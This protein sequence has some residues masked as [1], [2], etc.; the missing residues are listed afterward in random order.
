MLSCSALGNLRSS[1][2]FDSRAFD[3]NYLGAFITCLWTYELESTDGPVLWLDIGNAQLRC[4]QRYTEAAAYH[5][6]HLKQRIVK[7]PRVADHS[8]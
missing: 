7:M 4:E 2:K 3:L 8:K 6:K 5:L 1:L